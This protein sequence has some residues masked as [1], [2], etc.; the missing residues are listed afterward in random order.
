LRAHNLPAGDPVAI[1]LSRDGGVTFEPIATDVPNT[2][3]F[4]WIASGPDTAE[5]RVRVASLGA[6]PASG[7]GAAFQIVTAAIAV[8]SPS[9]GASWAI[10]TARTIS[11]SSSNLPPADTVRVELSRDGGASWTT[12]A[13][14]ALASGSLAWTA[15][16][17]ATTAAIVRVSA[18]GSVPVV[19]TSGA[20]AIGSPAVAVTSP[21]AGASW[22]IGTAQVITWNTNLLPTSTV[23]VQLSRNGGSTFT[24]LNSAAPNTGSYAWTAAGAA[25]TTAIVRVVANGASVNGVSGTF[26][27]VAA[28]VTVTAPNTVVIWTIGS[29]RTITW[30]HNAGAGAQ[31]KIEVSRSGSWSV[32][33]AAVPG[34]GPT[35]GSYDWTVTGPKATNAKVRVTWT[36]VTSAKDV[37]DVAFQIK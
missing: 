15:S 32:I 13:A 2:G 34:S 17:P 6:M 1:E 5:A 18:N 37:S 22:V 3:S 8:T 11:W 12:L 21:A 19:G 29:V 25:S 31:F 20:F 35:S 7:V 26:S 36:A 9:A 4:V 30:T 28:S 27:L 33:A 16:A 14:S 24:T 10:G 23:K